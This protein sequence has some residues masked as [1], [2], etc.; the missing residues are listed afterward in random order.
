LHGHGKLACSFHSA[1]VCDG[2]GVGEADS[3]LHEL[4]EHLKAARRLEGVAKVFNCRLDLSVGPRYGDDVKAGRVFEQLVFLEELEREFRK[5][6][7][8]VWAHRLDGMAGGVVEPGFDFDEN[9]RA[10]VDCDQVKFAAAAAQAAG[11]NAIAQALEELFGGMLAPVPQLAAAEAEHGL[12]SERR[13]H[14]AIP[15]FCR[16]PFTKTRAE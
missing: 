11:D 13:T 12:V 8:F 4:R 16:I 14:G 7:L 5:L 10:T 15:F 1:I 2:S 6:L 9:H 3:K